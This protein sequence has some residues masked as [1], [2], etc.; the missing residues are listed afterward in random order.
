VIHR[1]IAIGP[2]RS[3]QHPGGING[4]VKIHDF[5]MGEFR[6]ILICFLKKAH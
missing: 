6:G 4:K 2:E 3:D 5:V 1:A